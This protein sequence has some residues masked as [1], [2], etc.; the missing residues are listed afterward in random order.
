MIKNENINILFYFL[1]IN[2]KNSKYIKLLQEII[3]LIKE[4]DNEK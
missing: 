1:I 4:R 3:V 2:V